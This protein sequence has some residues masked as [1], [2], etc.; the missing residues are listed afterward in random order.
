ML[1]FR[2]NQWYGNLQYGNVFEIDL[3]MV[4]EHIF[5]NLAQLP[6]HLP[7][8]LP[9]GSVP[10]LCVLSLSQIWYF[11]KQSLLKL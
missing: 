5:K 7:R 1:I 3:N 10:L 11:S 4:I 6:G 2:E 9:S 8:A